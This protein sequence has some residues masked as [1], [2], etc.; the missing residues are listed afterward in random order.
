MSG[1]SERLA[2]PNTSLLPQQFFWESTTLPGK[3]WVG[4]PPAVDPTG[5]KMILD[6]GTTAGGGPFLPLTGGTLTGPLYYTATGGT[7]SRSAQ[8]RAADVANV[9]DF[10]ADPTG[11]LDSAPAI[12][13]AA[14]CVAATGY[15]KSVHLPAGVY[16]IRSQIT[17]TNGQSLSGD[18]QGNTILTVS[19]DFDPSVTSVIWIGNTT[20]DPGPTIRDLRIS[21][22][23]PS[24][25]A[26]RATFKTLAAGGTSHTGG[27]GVQYPWVI[28]Q[29]AS[30]GTGRVTIRNVRIE[31]AWNGITDNGNSGIYWV[32][33]LQLSAINC[34]FDLGSNGIMDWSHWSDIEFWP[35]G[36]LSTGQQPI[37]MDGNTIFARLGA[38][39][40]LN[41]QNISSFHGQIIFTA[42][43]AG[44]WFQFTN[45]SLDGAGATLSVA[46]AFFLQFSNLYY[47]A[48]ANALRP[49][50]AITGAGGVVRTVVINGWYAHSGSAFPFVSM[51]GGT[52]FS[53]VNAH[54]N[55][56]VTTVSAISV[57]AENCVLVT[58]KST[59]RPR[60]PGRFRW[61]IRI[62]PAPCRLITWTFRAA[63]G[64]VAVQFN[65]D[66]INNLLGFVYLGAGWT[67]SVVARANGQYGPWAPMTALTAGN[68]ATFS[69]LS[70]TGTAATTGIASFGGG[71]VCGPSTGSSNTDI[72]KQICL[73]SGATYGFGVTA[74]RIN[75][76]VPAS[77]AHVFLVNGGDVLTV[78]N[79]GVSAAGHLQVGS[80]SGPTWTTGGGA[81]SSTQPV[82]SI[83]S[84][85]SGAP[86]A[87]LYVSAGAGTWN[88]VASV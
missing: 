29:P 26:S 40:G 59:R 64:G 61:F 32:D 13:A 54:L 21:F 85:T 47:T 74:N 18:G 51:S 12:N 66:N 71:I 23:Q 22:A 24:D 56:E 70:V 33:G 15:L 27:T 52:E 86:G 62:I 42:A 1:V 83:Y 58:A 79:T 11:V 17:L 36:F 44:G 46:A 60:L 73:Y 8:D 3:I 30:G 50:I 68:P 49:A 77:S 31:A 76:N 7:V 9:L 81:P 80:T 38:V 48:A 87:R 5:L 20:I 75:Y 78:N 69:T 2:P 82:G 41:A 34:G 14:A 84:N 35:F 65:Q 53:I 10:G 43:A 67:N 19:D 4:V 28:S 25:A 6:L 37:W 57:T 72:S 39:N 55:A 88:A 16:H 63:P 45:L